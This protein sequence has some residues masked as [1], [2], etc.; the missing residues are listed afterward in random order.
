MA[1]FSVSICSIV[2][3]AAFDPK[4]FSDKN[5]LSPCQRTPLPPAHDFQHARTNFWRRARA[6]C[7]IFFAE[8][9]ATP[10]DFRRF[11]VRFLQ[12]SARV[13]SLF[14]R[15][16]AAHCAPNMRRKSNVR[17]RISASR[18][19]ISRHFFRRT[20]RDVARF[21]IFFLRN[22][23]RSARVRSQFRRAIARRTCA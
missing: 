12:Q 9:A 15:A 4:Y 2:F 11:F 5:I 13:R 6:F 17:A 1:S 8:R 18:S 10:R 14:R 23:Q 22:L 21:S 19:R 20:R 3:E 7:D 16:I